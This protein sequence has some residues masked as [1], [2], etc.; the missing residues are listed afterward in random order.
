MQTS[1]FDYNY[2]E[3]LVATEPKPQFRAMWVPADGQGP[4]EISPTEISTLFRPGDVLVINDTKVLRRRVMALNGLEILFLHSEPCRNNSY[5]AETWAVL[6]PAREVRDQEKF[7]LPGGVTARLVA[8]GLPQKIE[9]S[10]ALDENYFLKNG[11][12][13]L[14]PYIQKARGVRR[15]HPEEEKWY[16]TAWATQPG[17]HAAPTASLHFTQKNLTDLSAHGVKVVPI[18]LHVG[19]GTFLP[20]KT[21]ELEQHKMHAEFCSLPPDT[22]RTLCEARSQG[23]RVWALGT[24]VTR[25]LESWA[26]GG[27]KENEDGGFSGDTDIFIRPGFQFEVVDG[28]LTNFHQPRSTLLALVSAFVG[29]EN[30]LSAYRWAI[31]REFRL[32]SYGDLSIWERQ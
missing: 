21:E 14:P 18:T 15:N 4:R 2:P 1:D 12:L 9:V 16:Q 13:A 11:E 28:L 3:R 7:D 25:A 27:L 8:R 31:E 6:F 10:H 17:S 32:F 26:H 29:H 19:I 5:E 23:R 22:V 30:A 20:V 24:T